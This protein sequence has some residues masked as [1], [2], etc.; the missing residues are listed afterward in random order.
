MENFQN[1]SVEFLI[2]KK[3]DF[4]VSINDKILYSKNDLIGCD[5]NR[6]PHENEITSLI[7]TYIIPLK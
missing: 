7:K 5:N 1:I 6:F 2:G 3:G 4:I